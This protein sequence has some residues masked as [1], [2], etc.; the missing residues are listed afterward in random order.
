MKG[1]N[2]KAFT[3]KVLV[4]LFYCSLMGGSPSLTKGGRMEVRLYKKLLTL[5]NKII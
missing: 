4:F 3:R 2:Y 1:T 5:D